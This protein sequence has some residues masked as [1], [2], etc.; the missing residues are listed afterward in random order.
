MGRL[1]NCIAI[2]TGAGCVGPGWG[3]GRATCYRLAQ[4]GATVIGI[5]KSLSAME[6]TRQ[7]L[8]EING[9]FFSYELDVTDRN[10]VN[11]FFYKIQGEHKNLD[12]LVNNVG[13]NIFGGIDELTLENWDSQIELNLSS[14]FS[15]TK[16]VV[17]G[18]KKQK[19]G[20]IINISSTSGIRWTGS[21]HIGYAAAKGGLIQFTRVLAVELAPYQIRVNSVL[22]GQLNTPLVEK[23]LSKIQA[24][25]DV[26]KLR[27]R[28]RKRIPLPID[29][30]GIDTANAVLFLA[31][32]EARFITGTELVVD[33]GMS[34][35]CD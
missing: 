16:C 10:A 6:E 20:S 2:V 33:G 19:R 21:P 26:E 3:N 8:K 24:N 4:E 29:A 12:I 13:G 11:S 7:L 25:G 32:D 35:R 18:M 15:V 23:T 28:R 14:I 9:K 30:N 1:E 31:S 5:D 22:P 34:V 27:E 17:A